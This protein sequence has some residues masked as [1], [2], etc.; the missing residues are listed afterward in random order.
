MVLIGDLS[1]N[2]L[3]NTGS[4]TNPLKVKWRRTF[5]YAEVKTP[6][7]GKISFN[8]DF[9]GYVCTLLMNKLMIQQHKGNGDS[10][11]VA[12]SSFPQKEGAFLFFSF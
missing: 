4:V 2:G 9:V 7:L 3:R 11:V 10:A 1:S 12:R 5:A 6:G 8:A